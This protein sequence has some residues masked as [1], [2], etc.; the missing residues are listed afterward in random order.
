[1]EE[2]TIQLLTDKKVIESK[3]YVQVNDVPVGKP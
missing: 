2:M 1:M 3:L